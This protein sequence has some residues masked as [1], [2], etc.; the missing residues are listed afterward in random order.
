M[1]EDKVHAQK[2]STDKESILR[3]WKA[4]WFPT[5]VL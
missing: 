1:P 5:E 3:V 2:L 4:S